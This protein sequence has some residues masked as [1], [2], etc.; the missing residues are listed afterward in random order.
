MNET[1]KKN[2][3]KT[4]KP[5]KDLIE[6]AIEDFRNKLIK[7]I[8]QNI[9]ELAIDLKGVKN[10]DSTGLGIL[11]AASNSLNQAGGIGQLILTNVPENIENLLQITGLNRF[12]SMNAG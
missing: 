5:G 3:R 2:A 7:T 6:S 8:D 4:V 12:F 1:R 9:S 11:V 10:I